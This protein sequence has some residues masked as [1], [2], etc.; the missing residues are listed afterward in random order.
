MSPRPADANSGDFANSQI[1]DAFLEY[2]FFTLIN[3]G[4][5]TADKVTRKFGALCQ[6]GFVS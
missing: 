5:N 3:K 6:S 1:L 4:F 2:D